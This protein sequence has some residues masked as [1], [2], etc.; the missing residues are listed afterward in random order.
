MASRLTN[1]FRYTIRPT[2]RTI[3]RSTKRLYSSSPHEY[4]EL[5]QVTGTGIGLLYGGY[6]TAVT[7]HYPDGYFYGLMGTVFLAS[8]GTIVGPLLALPIIGFEVGKY[9]KNKNKN[10]N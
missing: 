7:A 5:M 8:F 10:N 9:V 2:N 3:S 1:L 6:K 4:N